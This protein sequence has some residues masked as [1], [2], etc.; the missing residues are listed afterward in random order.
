MTDYTKEKVNADWGE[1]KVN[2]KTLKE[3]IENGEADEEVYVNSRP[4]GKAIVK[5]MSFVEYFET[6]AVVDHGSVTSVVGSV[7][8]MTKKGLLTFT[9]MTHELRPN[10]FDVDEK[11]MTYRM[12]WD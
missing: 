11:T 1:V 3:M 2:L 7:K 8:G 12:W 4:T 5:F 9:A 10:E 6:F